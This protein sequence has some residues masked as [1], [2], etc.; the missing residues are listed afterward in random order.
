MPVGMHRYQTVGQLPQVIGK[1]SVAG[2]G[3]GPQRVAAHLGDDEG[4]Q[5]GEDRRALNE[6]DV[7][8]PVVGA[9]ARN[10][11]E[12]EDL[13]VLG[14]LRQG[15]VT[16]SQRTEPRG[17]GD[18]FSRPDRLVP[19]KDHPVGQQLLADGRY[20]G[21]IEMCEVHSGDLRSDAPG[22]APRPQLGGLG[23]DHGGSSLKY[24]NSDG[25]DHESSQES[26]TAGPHTLTGSTAS[27][28]SA[29]DRSR[30]SI[31]VAWWTV[32]S[33]SAPVSRRKSS[34]YS[35]TS[36]GVPAAV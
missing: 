36:G 32:I 6:G 7:G 16:L 18:L 21:V 15:G 12:V 25:F 34:R 4:A 20:P 1:V 28:S 30:P 31:V 26:P 23:D 14:E 33:S 13:A 22:Q 10:G 11:V 5:H 27:A 17:K 8:V 2:H 3:I 9:G 35:P 24:R 29:T 19:E